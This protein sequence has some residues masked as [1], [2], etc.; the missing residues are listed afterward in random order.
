MPSNLVWY[1]N[2]DSW[3]NLYEQ[4]IIMGSIIHHSE[5]I[6]VRS[7][8]FVQETE[9]KELEANIGFL[10]EFGINISEKTTSTNLDINDEV[11]EINVDFAPIENLKN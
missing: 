8:N 4:R 9:S 10:I 1:D 6:S 3:K 7:V 2:V 11:I 5:K